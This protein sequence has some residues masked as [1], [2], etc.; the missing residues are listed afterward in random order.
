VKYTLAE[1]LLIEELDAGKAKRVKL[2]ID[3][4]VRNTELMIEGRALRTVIIRSRPVEG[5][6]IIDEKEHVFSRHK[7]YFN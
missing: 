5:L 2:T 6:K 3:F 7:T 4:S 1:D